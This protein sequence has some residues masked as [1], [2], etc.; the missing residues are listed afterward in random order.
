M[1]GDKS[2]TLIPGGPEAPIPPRRAGG[3]A[4]D[5]S[6]KPQASW[7]FLVPGVP[8]G[9][10]HQIAVV[11]RAP[12]G[13]LY[14]RILN[15]FRRPGRKG[16]MQEIRIRARA[17]GVKLQE[18]PVAVTIKAGFPRPKSGKGRQAFWHSIKPDAENVVKPILD[19]LSGLAWKDDCQVARV[20]IDKVYTED[21][22]GWTRIM[23]EPLEEKE[24]LLLKVKSKKVKG[25]S[26]D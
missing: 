16:W 6:L 8:Q 20:S 23:I 3:S 13:H 9:R 14:A 19:A 10:A 4:H 11:R 7:S 12:R 25:K 21:P 15:D 22:A 5:S 1:T 18:G 26:V 24:W 17:A 2:F